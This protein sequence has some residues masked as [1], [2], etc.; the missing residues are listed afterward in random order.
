MKCILIILF[1]FIA[2]ELHAQSF[3]KDSLRT[4]MENIGI[5]YIDFSIAQA[6]H[7]SANFRSDLFINNHNLFGM[8]MPERRKTTAIGVRRHYAVYRSWKESV[9]DFLLMQKGILKKHPTYSLYISYIYRNYASDPLYKQK[10]Q[11]Y[12]K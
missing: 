1:L 7:E 9:D 2:P 12:I 10:L 4:Y 3:N 11:K 8:R 5:K 6:I